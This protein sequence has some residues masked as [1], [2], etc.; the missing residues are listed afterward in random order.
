MVLPSRQGT[1]R[2]GRRPA[3]QGTHGFR[4]A[5][6][7]ERHGAPSLAGAIRSA[8]ELV[9]PAPSRQSGRAR[10]EEARAAAIA[11]VFHAAPLSQS[12]WPREAAAPDV[13]SDSRS[14]ASRGAAV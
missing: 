14:R 12:T 3:S 7:D 2:S 13:A 1:A 10:R 5:G 11:V 4:A 8:Q 6:V 9:L